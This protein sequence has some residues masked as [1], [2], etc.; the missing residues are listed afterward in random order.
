MG[1]NSPTSTERQVRLAVQRLHETPR[2]QRLFL[3][4]NVSAIHPPNAFYLS[5]T[6]EDTIASHAAA[7]AY[8]D[9]QLPPLFSALRQR[10]P[11]LVIICSDHG[12][13]YGE[14]GYW[15]HRLSHSVVWTVPYA[16][17][18][19]PGALGV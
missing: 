1:I 9:R 5:G 10:G 12:T 8:V 16:E 14:D 18:I 15:G 11:S 13:A 17:L 19:L 2:A 7:L 3:F 6:K 4:I